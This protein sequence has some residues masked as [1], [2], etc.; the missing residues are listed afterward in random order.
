MT[1][2]REILL[3]AAAGVLLLAATASSP[4]VEELR[5]ANVAEVKGGIRISW[6]RGHSV[7]NDQDEMI[8]TISEF[9]VGRDFALFAILQVGDFL[10]LNDHLVAVPFKTLVVDQSGLRVKLPGATRKA[11]KSFPEFRFAD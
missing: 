7:V 2:T 4:A 9:V 6:L 8:G 3:A 11:L 10:E 1:R 5:S